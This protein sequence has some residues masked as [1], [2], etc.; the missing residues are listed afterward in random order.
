[1]KK[2]N[3]VG[4]VAFL[5]LFTVLLPS[6]G[7]S[8]D[9]KNKN[10]SVMFMIAEQN[11]GQEHIVYWWRWL[12]HR[13]Y[14]SGGRTVVSGDFNYKVVAPQFDLSVTETILKEEFI[15]S[16]IDVVDIS[17]AKEGKI[18]VSNVYK[19]VDLKADV[20]MELGRNCGADIVVKGQA[21]VKKQPSTRRVGSYIANMT[22]SAIRV[23]DGRVLGAARGEGLARHI[24][25]ITGGT[26]ALER[27]SIEVA[28]KLINKI[29]VN[30]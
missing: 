19:Y 20:M 2:R 26:K 10:P 30:R 7:F 14:Y 13:S 1:M 4:V 18:K 25:D 3:I 15:N 6:K 24:S 29:M 27:A 28:E 11:I 17:R 21:I 12:S 22:V 9:L 23:K 16:G 8:E 5:L